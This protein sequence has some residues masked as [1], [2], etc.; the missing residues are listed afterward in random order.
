[1]RSDRKEPKKIARFTQSM[2][3][4]KAVELMS[5][6]VAE[7]LRLGRRPAVV[8]LRSRWWACWRK[9]Y[10]LSM[11]HP[12]RKYKC[13]LPV[14][15]ERLERGWLNV[16]RVRAAC[17]LLTQQDPEMENF[18]QSPF[19]HNETGSAGARTLAVAGSQCHLWSAT[20]QRG[21]G[22]RPIS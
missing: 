10:G 2:L 11:R 9:E 1:M 7:E 14:L 13:P 21:S 5:E 18:D 6:Y 4:T 20:A 17:V 3:Q 16:F 8:E 19:H 15:E 12:N 22:G